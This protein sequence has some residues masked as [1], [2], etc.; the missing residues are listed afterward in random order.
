VQR[1]IDLARADRTVILVAHRLSTMLDADRIYVFHDGL[2]VEIGTYQELKENDG[3]FAELIHCS[4]T[5]V[6]EN[7]PAAGLAAHQ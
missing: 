7:K 5:G 4:Q 6:T 3:I 2:I 1:A